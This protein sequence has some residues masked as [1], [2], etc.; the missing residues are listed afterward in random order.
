MQVITH[1][2]SRNGISFSIDS[3]NC[4]VF[5]PVQCRLHAHARRMVK[6]TRSYKHVLNCARSHSSL[7][8]NYELETVRAD[9]LYIVRGRGFGHC[10]VGRWEKKP[11]IFIV[12]LFGPII[13]WELHEWKHA[14]RHMQL[15]IYKYLNA[16]G[17][18]FYLLLS[19]IDEAADC[20][21]ILQME[22]G[23]QDRRR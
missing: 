2:M 9:Q 1:F 17:Q 4:A 13:C 8:V 10:V 18:T 7:A 22:R 14:R 12:R 15:K 20:K 11:G 19:N 21:D 23:S 5:C 6:L 16:Y 3:L